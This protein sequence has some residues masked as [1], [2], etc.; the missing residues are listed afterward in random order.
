MLILFS[1][2]HPDLSLVEEAGSN[3]AVFT[4]IGLF[5]SFMSR[6]ARKRYGSAFSFIF[7][8][9]IIDCSDCGIRINS[10][11]LL[12]EG[13]ANR[14][15]AQGKP[16][17]RVADRSGTPSGQLQ[18]DVRVKCGLLFAYTGKPYFFTLDSFFNFIS[19][20]TALLLILP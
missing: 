18:A 17:R 15:L 5:A 6:T 14:Q 10:Q 2:R 20:G 4:R 7:S 19:Q 9:G 13:R 8:R 3:I 16:P 11:Y 1:G 12:H